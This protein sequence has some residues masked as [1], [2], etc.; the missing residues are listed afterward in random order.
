MSDREL[1]TA[2]AHTAGQH[3][4]EEPREAR[5]AKEERAYTETN[6]ALRRNGVS[7]GIIKS[8]EE[9]SKRQQRLLEI[10]M[11]TGL[12]RSLKARGEFIELM[13][14]CCHLPEVW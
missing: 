5:L 3:R 2:I 8:H 9:K 7:Q 11:Q 4:E 6:G 13:Q 10:I 12:D 14:N 1:K